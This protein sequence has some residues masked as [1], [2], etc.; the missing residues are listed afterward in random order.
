[1]VALIRSLPKSLRQPVN[2]VGERARG[3]LAEYGPEDG[4]LLGVLA[5]FGLMVTI[6]WIRA[7]LRPHQRRAKPAS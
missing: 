1:M 2:P 3:F 7:M 6:I 4:P 5:A